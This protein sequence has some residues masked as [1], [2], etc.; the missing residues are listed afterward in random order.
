[1]IIYAES[2]SPQIRVS[3]DPT[4]RR[5]ARFDGGASSSVDT[6]TRIPK[7][8]SILSYSKGFICSGGVGLLHLFEK[9][10]DTKEPFK[11]KP[12]KVNNLPAMS[13]S[14]A[15]RPQTPIQSGITV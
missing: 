15:A 1:M 12:V 8:L 7:V 4:T 13:L 2:Q 3:A 11:R 9:S 5:P 10:D 14:L 6:S